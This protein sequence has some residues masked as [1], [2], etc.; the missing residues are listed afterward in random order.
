MQGNQRIAARLVG[1]AIW[2]LS[3][4]AFALLTLVNFGF[5]AGAFLYWSCWSV[6]LMLITLDW[7]GQ[8]V[9]PPG[10]RMRRAIFAGWVIGIIGA[11]V[12][13]LS[14][15]KPF[16]DGK[17]SIVI[18]PIL[19]IYGLAPVAVSLFVIVALARARFDPERLSA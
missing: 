5:T 19:A 6:P 9:A 16:W 18:L 14:A 10:L 4:L 2:F 15:D 17:E 7:L 11:L 8:T 12:L 3:L 1:I 13:T